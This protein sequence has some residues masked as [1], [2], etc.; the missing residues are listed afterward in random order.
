MTVLN[1]TNG[2]LKQTGQAKVNSGQR[3]PSVFL[4]KITVLGIPTPAIISNF[5]F[6]LV[7]LYA[8]AMYGFSGVRLAQGSRP[9]S[10]DS[11]EKGLWDKASRL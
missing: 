5:E 10:H 2:G 9:Q 8:Q 3:K 7:P 1:P 11:G 4:R 6:G